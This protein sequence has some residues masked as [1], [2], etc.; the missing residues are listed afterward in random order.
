MNDVAQKILSF[1]FSEENKP[2]WFAKNEEFDKK[3]IE[4]FMPIYNDL[5][6]KEI[7]D[8]PK[9][10]LA[11]IILFDQFPRNMFRNDEKSF[12]T[13]GKARMLARRVLKKEYDNEYSNEEKPFSYMPFMHSENLD[14]QNLCIELFTKLGNKESLH[15]AELHRDI[16]KKYSRFPHRNKILGRESTA[17]EIEFLKQ[18]NSSF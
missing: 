9:N 5:E 8:N 13:D 12:A 6:R 11:Q 18:P 14:D 1:W 3:I 10:T 7:E 4:Q 2:Y 15:F 17:E 16:I